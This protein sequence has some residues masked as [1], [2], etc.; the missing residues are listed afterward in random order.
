MGV[1]LGM[2]EPEFHSPK[3]CDIVLDCIGRI[4]PHF[5]AVKETFMNHDIGTLYT[6]TTT[7]LYAVSGCNK[8]NRYIYILNSHIVLATLYSCTLHYT[9][10]Y[11][12][13][14]SVSTD[15]HGELSRLCRNDV[16]QMALEKIEEMGVAPSQEQCI[17]HKV[18]ST[19]TVVDVDAVLIMVYELYHQEAEEQKIGLLKVQYAY[20]YQGRILNCC[21]KCVSVCKQVQ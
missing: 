19:Q 18:M 21:H 5:G 6:P 20:D 11:A 15:W 16:L 4:I 13:L 3:L 9:S 2:L 8:S 14:R 17:E 10:L 7:A 12:S 1:V